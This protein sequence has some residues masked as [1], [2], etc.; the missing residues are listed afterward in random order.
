MTKSGQV[1][2][3][4]VRLTLNVKTELHQKLKVASAMTRTTMGEL[5]EQLIAD[6]LT[7]ILRRGIRGVK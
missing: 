3:G 7:E 4:D 5:V 6:S 1:P 2:H